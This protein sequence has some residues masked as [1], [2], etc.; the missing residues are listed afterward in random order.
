MYLISDGCPDQEEAEIVAYVRKHAVKR[1]IT[2]NSISFSCVEPRANYFLQEVAEMTGGTFQYFIEDMAEEIFEHPD[3]FASIGPLPIEDPECY[4]VR[5]EM[6]LARHH[7]SLMTGLWDEIQHNDLER[8]Q[9]QRENRPPQ[10]R[11]HVTCAPPAIPQRKKRA[12]TKQVRE[13]NVRYDENDTPI[14]DSTTS[15]LQTDPAA[16]YQRMAEVLR[17]MMETKHKTPTDDTINLAISTEAWLERNSLQA[18]GL[19]LSQVLKQATVPR[20]PAKFSDIMGKTVQ[21]K[22]C[23]MT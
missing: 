15:L 11:Y 17:R 9:A 23:W 2:V 7:L 4:H 3:Q 14:W 1:G 13:R 16:S 18:R 6:K 8:I 5:E 22:V 12:S 10:F 21:G 20:L 19:L